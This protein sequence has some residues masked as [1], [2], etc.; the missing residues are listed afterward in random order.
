MAYTIVSLLAKP[1]TGDALIGLELYRLPMRRTISRSPHETMNRADHLNTCDTGLAD[2]P[3][4]ATVFHPEWRAAL[5]QEVLAMPA[6]AVPGYPMPYWLPMM[7][8]THPSIYPADIQARVESGLATLWPQMSTD[9]R[10]EMTTRLRD[11]D[12]IVACDEILAAAAF[13]RQFGAA[14]VKWPVAPKGQR[15]PEF[16]V[17]FDSKRWAVECKSLQ[18][19]AQVRE[20]N[21]N[22]L[23]T[24]QPWVA[25]LDLNHDPN[26]L[27]REVIKKIKRAQGGGPSVVLLSSQTP[28]LMPGSMDEQIRRILCT[29]SAVNLST[30]ERPI[31]VACLTFTIVQ[32]VWFCDSACA[33]A[34]ID[35]ALRERIRKAIAEGFVL[36]GDGAML[37]EC[38]WTDCE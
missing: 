10:S 25:S 19:N 14:A 21:A 12:S 33:S 20:L 5:R 34:G 1:T 7:Q 31:A 29:P 3:L 8:E 28:W 18:D 23:A 38:A 30:A 27:R 22:M 6:D 26:R 9:D 32:G 16:F 17:E 35:P 37:T 15:R 4:L 36:R 24:G 2:K 13:A 11:G